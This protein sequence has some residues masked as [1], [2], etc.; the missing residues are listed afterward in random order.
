MY[1]AIRENIESKKLFDHDNKLLITVSGGAD[2]IVLLDIINRLR[3]KYEIAHCNFSLRGAES[4]LDQKLVEQ[5]AE[6]YGC[7]LHLIQFDTIKYAEENK[8]SIEMAARDLRYEWFEKIKDENQIDY[9]LTAHHRDDSIET[10]IMNLARGTGVTGL[11][12]ISEER[13]HIVRPLLQV[14]RESIIEYIER[15]NLSYREDQS[16][17]DTKYRRNLIRHK[18]I[19][20]L[21]ELN[22]KFKENV[23]RTIENLKETKNLADSYISSIDLEITDNCFNTS[24]IADNKQLSSILFE[25]LKDYKLTRD[26]ILKL[27][28]AISSRSV[29]KEFHSHTHRFIVDRDRVV[30]SEG[31]SADVD[32]IFNLEAPPEQFKV[33]FVDNKEP[34]IRSN[35]IAYINFEKIEGEMR[36]RSWRDGDK[37]KPLGMNHFKKL[38]RFFIDIKLSRLEKEN[39]LVL[40]NNGLIVWV[41]GKR[42]DNRFKVDNNTKQILKIEIDESYSI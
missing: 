29:G 42:L 9:I 36:L 20:I 24:K 26:N 25:Q 14:G 33:T 17:K 34:L 23:A 6:R 22:P 5:L 27:S 2:S 32:K 13:D 12:G 10:L 19:P 21:E 28:R 31:I 38:S 39:M 37:F 7:K 41:V 3:Y 30:I 15:N 35:R 4:D 1:R 40:E 11:T 18:I 8:I 16:N